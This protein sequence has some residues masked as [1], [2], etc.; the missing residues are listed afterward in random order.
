MALYLEGILDPWIS[1]LEKRRDL[2]DSFRV[3]GK[4]VMFIGWR[5]FPL[6][7]PLPLTTCDLQPMRFVINFSY[8]WGY[9]ENI[10]H[11]SAIPLPQA[12]Y[13]ENASTPTLGFTLCL[14]T[15][16]KSS[17]CL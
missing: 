12:P 16:L 11:D 17:L 4:L 1:L 15:W 5:P 9:S 13:F 6:K 8:G 2:M 7:N 3:R 10:V 14:I